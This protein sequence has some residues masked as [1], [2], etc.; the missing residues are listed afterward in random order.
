MGRKMHALC[1]SSKRRDFLDG[2][3]AVK[4]IKKK[5]P[6]L[7][8]PKKCVFHFLL[9]KGACATA[10]R[11]RTQGSEQYMA[12]SFMLIPCDLFSMFCHGQWTPLS[13]STSVMCG[14]KLTPRQNFMILSCAVASNNF[15]N[16]FNPH[17]F[18]R[19]TTN[20]IKTKSPKTCRK[21]NVAD[22][23]WWGFC[24]VLTVF[25]HSLHTH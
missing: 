11:T 14:I 23:A 2:S 22:C 5:Y 21:R 9:N 6:P 20:K 24:M 16:H 12:V 1:K 25:T 8:H 17:C 10:L 3:L 7:P 18:S 13:W 19:K 4:N 15:R